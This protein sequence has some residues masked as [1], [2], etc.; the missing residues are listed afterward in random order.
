MALTIEQEQ[1]DGVAVLR[2]RGDL[3]VHTKEELQARLE[4]LLD[5]GA[6]TIR[7]DLTNVDYIGSVAIAVMVGVSKRLVR[8]G[9][10]LLVRP[11]SNETRRH[12]GLLNLDT[13]LDIEG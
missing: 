2:L 4:E 6:E 11:G 1:E 13:L 5:Q 9:G 10:R 3:D 8:K 12:F 7:L